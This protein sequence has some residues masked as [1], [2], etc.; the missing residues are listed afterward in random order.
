MV[1]EVH[2]KTSL[3]KSRLFVVVLV[4]TTALKVL[5]QRRTSQEDADEGE[6]V[7]LLLNSSVMKYFL[8]M[9]FS[10]FI[11]AQSEVH[12]GLVKIN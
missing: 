5:K 12:W 9:T 6:N 7:L 3:F 4:A 10:D 8:E 1:L 2:V 11:F